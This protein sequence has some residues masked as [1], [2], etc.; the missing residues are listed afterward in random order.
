[1]DCTQPR[2]TCA[3]SGIVA[4]P[5]EKHWHEAKGIERKKITFEF[6]EIIFRKVVSLNLK[7]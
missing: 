4:L 2:A 7:F 1:M 5:A 3:S 6:L